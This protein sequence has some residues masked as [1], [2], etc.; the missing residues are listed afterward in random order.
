MLTDTQIRKAQKGER[1]YKLA[2][3]G[4]LYLLVTTTGAK[5]FRFKYRMFGREKLLTFGLYP[6]VGLVEARAKRDAA[7]ALIREGKDPALERKRQRLAGAA[8]AATTFEVMARSWYELAKGRWSPVHAADVET[9]LE[10]DVFKEIGALPIRDVDTALVLATLRKVERRGSIETARRLR[11]RI[12]AVFAFAISEGAVSID[13]AASVQKALKPLPKKGRQPSIVDRIDEPDDALKAARKVLADAEGSGASPV[14]KL[15]S[16]L[17]ALTAVRPGVVRGV[18]WDEFEA[19]DWQAP[20][21]PGSHPDALWR[22]PAGRMKLVLDRKDEEAFEHLVTL[23]WQA[24]A[25][26]QAIRRLTARCAF[27][28]PSQ[29]H[30]HRPMSEN[31]IGY[32][33]NRVGYHGRHVPH[34]WRAAFSTIMNELAQRAGHHSDRKVID[35]MLAHVPKDK[36]EG[37]YNRAAHMS[38]RRE[39]AQQ[40][41]DLLLEGLPPAA[42]LLTGARRGS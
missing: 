40:W 32:L 31:A 10:R 34:G 16:R 42:D 26:L 1:D 8:S 29:R 28:F 41:A 2:D 7:R 33:Y 30:S 24:V 19:I 6:D 36:V 12:S 5:S 25:V 17:L 21:A 15:G 38:R 11:Q 9:S 14:T 4:G 39:L 20:A 18:G 22:V 3:S 35:L 13:P 23:P 27:V 37:A